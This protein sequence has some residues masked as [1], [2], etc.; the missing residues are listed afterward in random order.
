MES[1]TEM[2]GEARIVTVIDSFGGSY[3]QRGEQWA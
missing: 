2:Q 1:Y 3:P